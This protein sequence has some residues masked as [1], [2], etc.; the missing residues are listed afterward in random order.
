MSVQSWVNALFAFSTRPVTVLTLLIYGAL[1]VSTIWIHEVPPSPPRVQKQL[2]LDL[3]VAWRDLQALTTYPHPYHSHEND[4]VRRYI[5]DRVNCAAKEF[6]YVH[7][8]DD[9]E[10]NATYVGGISNLAG[11][12]LTYFEG[13]NVLVKIDGYKSSDDDSNPGAV[14][15]SAHFDSVS[16]A[17]GATD[18]GMGVATLLQLVDYFAKN[19]PKRDV[20]FNINNGEEDGLNGAHAFLEH[21]WSALPTV[22]LNLEGAGS[23]GRPQL[24]RTSATDVTKA[25]RSARHPHGNVVSSDGFK[26]GLVRS[27][28]D[29][30]IYTKAGLEGL[31][32][33]FYRKRSRYHTKYDSVS[34]LGGR[35]SLWAMMEASVGSGKALVDLVDAKGKDSGAEVV[36]FDLFGLTMV[37]LEQNTLF[38]INI[39]TLVVGPIVI[40]ALIFLLATRDKLYWSSQG[41]V[42]FP[43]A[44]VIG[45]AAAFGLAHAYA[46]IAPYAVYASPYPVFASLFCTAFL[47]I[48]VVLKTLSWYYPADD[49]PQ[50]SVVLFENYII[51]WVLLLIDAIF[52]KSFKMGGGYFVTFFH[53]ATLAALL[54]TLVEMLCA[55]TVKMRT[56]RSQS[57]NGYNSSG[58]YQATS[59]G[60]E[61]TQNRIGNEL[62]TG[63]EEV[64]AGEHEHDDVHATERTPLIPPEAEDYVQLATGVKDSH[65]TTPLWGVEFTLA[66]VFPVLLILQLALSLLTALGETLADGNSPIFVYVATAFFSVL[67][68]LPLAPFIHKI[69]K[70][71]PVALVLILIINVG[72]TMLTF[73]FSPAAPLKVYFQQTLD[74]D[75]GSLG[76][77]NTVTL[78]GVKEYLRDYV[79]PSIP[80]G[81]DA[82]RRGNGTVNCGSAGERKAGLVACSFEGL[83]PRVSPAMNKNLTILKR[84]AG[85]ENDVKSPSTPPNPHT[86]ELLSFSTTRIDASTGRITI[87]GAN[88]R[89]CRIYFDRPV[90]SVRVDGGN[91]KMQNGYAMPPDGVN[92]VRLWSRTWNR[93]FDVEVGW[94]GK[95]MSET[96]S[97]RV[98]CEWAEM[99]EERIPALD[100]IV[101]FLPTWAVVSK[102]NDGL[103]EGIRK[104][105]M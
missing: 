71:V 63:E 81:W 4:A 25:F 48:Y 15:F 17:P 30:Q 56:V 74:L 103:V 98:A 47:G 24:F 36:Y 90:T 68:V 43:L 77:N 84:G 100:E 70:L 38:I 37:V 89:A 54:L 97:G 62:V 45:C 80:S 50:R 102:L 72:Y 94:E 23:A 99:R 18:D 31:D 67:I 20:I 5:L 46:A 91:K 93:T 35:S 65:W 51:W 83:K 82:A 16:T 33:A 19:R 11:T 6:D 22:F 58:N 57:R 1:F 92:E 60:P 73:P 40:A 39:V 41:W 101:S 75:R 105:E 104:F 95:V 2:G 29:Y 9:I 66:T 3:D 85:K 32:L 59:N 64:R 76:E 7:I 69:Q 21:P 8:S 49:T 28:T 53:A 12:S 52:L 14:L 78:V 86:K 87:K 61:D 27:G 34:G 55:R 42:K 88:A 44:L 26:S 10:S 13:N 79:V 96:V